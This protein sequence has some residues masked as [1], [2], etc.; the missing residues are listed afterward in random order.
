M[1]D[2]VIYVNPDDCKML[3]GTLIYHVT[4][5]GTYDMGSGQ[6]RVCNPGDIIAFVEP[7]FTDVT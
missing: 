7:P 4:E 5:L 6:T 2:K 1:T 3:H